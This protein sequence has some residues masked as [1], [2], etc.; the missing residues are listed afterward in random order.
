LLHSVT[1]PSTAATE[2]APTEE[3]RNV[4]EDNEGSDNGATTEIMT[5]MD[6]EQ[7]TEVEVL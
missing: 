1:Q 4:Q 2:I 7:L 6:T 3:Q 5:E